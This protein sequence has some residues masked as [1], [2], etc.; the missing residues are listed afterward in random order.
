[1]AET[2]KQID[3]QAHGQ[4]RQIARDL[5]DFETSLIRGGGKQI[6]VHLVDLSPKGFHARTA[7]S[8]FERGEVVSLRLPII[9]LVP[10]RVMWGLKGC[11]GAQFSIPIDAR[12]Y[13]E[14]IA[15]I[16]TETSDNPSS[17]AR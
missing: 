11:F 4:R 6:A 17:A 7:A 14:L 5:I 13:L 16:G 1:M 9:G 8:R 10:G 3:E 15:R 12:H 2:K